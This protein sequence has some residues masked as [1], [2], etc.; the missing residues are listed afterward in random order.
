MFC[1]I[2]CKP[3]TGYFEPEKTNSLRAP[4]YPLVTIDPYTSAWSFT[5]KLNDDVI[6]HWTGAEFPL[7]GTLEVDGTHYL[8]SG[9][10]NIPLK[11]ILP[12]AAKEK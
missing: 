3:S 10:E 6:R 2:A 11:A 4:A 9:I 12:T 1:I 8:F 5:D 7:S